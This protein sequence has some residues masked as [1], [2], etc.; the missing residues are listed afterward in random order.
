MLMVT[1][2]VSETQNRVTAMF[3]RSETDYGAMQRMNAVDP[4]TSA[5]TVSRL[6]AS[7]VKELGLQQAITACRESHW[8]GVLNAIRDGSNDPDGGQLHEAVSANNAV[9]SAGGMTAKGWRTI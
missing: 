5:A 9:R 6:A 4:G 3:E 7:L 2:D 1:E 8:D